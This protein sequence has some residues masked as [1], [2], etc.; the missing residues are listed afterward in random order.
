MVTKNGA[1]KNDVFFV[2]WS[3]RDWSRTY[4]GPERVVVGNAYKFYGTISH[5]ILGGRERL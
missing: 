1:L 2:L 4:F 5:A 3:R